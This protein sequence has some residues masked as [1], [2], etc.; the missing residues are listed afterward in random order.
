MTGWKNWVIGLAASA[1]LI[2]GIGCAAFS[3]LVTPANI[4]KQAVKYAASA[5]VID[6]N[7]F[8]GYANL[9]KAIR[10]KAAVDAA[11]KVKELSLTQMMEKNKLDYAQL[12]DVSESNM[13]AS[14]AKEEQ[15][16]GEKGLLSMGLS[17]A[18]FGT[19][20]GLVG[21][22]RKRPGDITQ[23]DMESALSTVKGEV[24]AK[25]RQ[26]IEVVKGIQVVLDA[27]PKGDPVG[28]EIRKA[29]EK[30]SVDTRQAVAVAKTTV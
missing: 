28:D 18:G 26:F 25:D 21:L 15:L 12:S 3:T 6:A 13:K 4:D 27:H 11:F 20:T 2:A 17:L 22:M 24:T 29:L 16:F 1:L 8:R 14:Q 7:D 23:Q 19:L 5:G 9:D 30:Q 10:L